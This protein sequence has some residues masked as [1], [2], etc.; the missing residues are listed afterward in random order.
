[1]NFCKLIAGRSNTELAVKISDN[2]KI[3]LTKCVLDDFSNTELKVEILESIRG[4]DVF[5]L[6][7]GGFS[8][9]HSINDYLMELLSLVNT[10]KLSSARSI[11]VIIPC[12]F[13]ARSDKKDGRVPINGSLVAQMLEVSGA[14][15]IVSMDL[16]SG[17]IQGFARIPFD[18]LFAINIHIS[19]L[20]KT[21]FKG[22]TQEEI[23]KKYV[24]V[25]PDNGG[26]RRVDAYSTR[27]GMNY[28][29]LHKTRNYAEKSVVK[30]SVLVGDS[31]LISEKTGILIDDILSTCGT[32]IAA[33]EELKKYGMKDCIIIVT[34]G[35][36]SGNAI[37]KIS[38]CDMIKEVIT[39]NTLAQ[40][41]NVKQCKKITV[42]DISELL[43]E[44]IRRLIKGGSISEMFN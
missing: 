4:F 11:N 9:E 27:M 17:Q 7:T 14:T 16:H 31:E 37:T 2:L 20:M 36:F 29:T 6:Q 34:H 26:I 30:R 15:R 38:E 21:I 22:M 8:N 19:N 33:A 44:V 12:Y 39:T 43:S 5:I 18:N 23:N 41:E 1:M 28:V 10:C 24:L 3:P 13:Y 35:E 40:T 25:S 42:V 32:M